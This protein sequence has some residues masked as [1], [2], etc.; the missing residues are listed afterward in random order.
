[1][2]SKPHNPMMVM[3]GSALEKGAASLLTK[4][5]VKEIEKTIIDT[6]LPVLRG[7]LLLPIKKIAAG[8]T[9]YEWNKKDHMSAA[10]LIGKGGNF[11]RDEMSI[12]DDTAKIIK[13]GKGFEVFRED[14]LAKPGIDTENAQD[15]ARQVMEMEN[16]FIFTGSTHPAINGLIAAAGQTQVGTDWSAAIG[17]ADAYGDVLK[18][19]AKLEAQNFMGPYSLGLNPVNYGEAR[20]RDV[21]GGGTGE[22][23]LKS[24]LAD[25]VSE[26]VVDPTITLG[27]AIVM[28]KGLANSALLV[29]E[30]VT[31]EIFDMD[32]NQVMK[33]NVFEHVGIVVYQANSIGTLTG[34]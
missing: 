23:V 17:T 14:L 18:I 24:I 9:I 11:P 1:M 34:L 26:V 29:A 10:E 6:I 19:I 4:E 3:R 7:R 32:P 31:V 27:T 21:Q 13:I 8:K 12:A 15:A 30:D 20:R 16:S 28:Q 22:S 5:D 2:S 33:G 25:L